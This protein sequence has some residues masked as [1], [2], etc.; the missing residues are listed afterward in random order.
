MLTYLYLD[1]GG[2]PKYRAELKYSLISLQ[3][4]LAGEAARIAIYCDAPAAYR[5]WPVTA[6]GIADKIQPWSGAGYIITAS[7]RRRCR[8]R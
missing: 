8:T 7:S 5:R 1:Y 6:V 2:H 4:E 3:A